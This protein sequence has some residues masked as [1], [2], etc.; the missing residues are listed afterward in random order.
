MCAHT[1]VYIYIYYIT[2]YIYVY[3][4]Y[5]YKYKLRNHTRAY[6][7]I[8]MHN[9]AD[10]HYHIQICMQTFG[11]EVIPHPGAA[12]FF[13]G[14]RAT[15]AQSSLECCVFRRIRTSMGKGPNI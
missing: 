10:T 14:G 1:C 12:V 9:H 8:Y 13:L 4:Y 11:A 2:I 3:T 6:V 7:R 5:K 15:G